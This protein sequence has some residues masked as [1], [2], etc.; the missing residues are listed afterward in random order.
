MNRSIEELIRDAM[1]IKPHKTS[2]KRILY[3][4]CIIIL[5]MKPYPVYNLKYNRAM[6]QS[7]VRLFSIIDSGYP[8]KNCH[9]RQQ[10][11]LRNQNTDS[12]ISQTSKF[13]GQNSSNNPSQNKYS[14]SNNLQNVQGQL[15]SIRQIEAQTPVNN[16]PICIFV[17]IHP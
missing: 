5:V 13:H 4:N 1:N 10:N 3:I 17:Q 15:F 2:Y 7:K 8:M 14:Q 11:S 12:Q 6:F 9:K 16:M